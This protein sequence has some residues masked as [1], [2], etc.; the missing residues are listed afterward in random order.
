[1]PGFSR[2]FRF[3][4]G[5]SRWLIPKKLSSRLQPGFSFCQEKSG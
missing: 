3:A 5:F 2:H 4:T 1:M